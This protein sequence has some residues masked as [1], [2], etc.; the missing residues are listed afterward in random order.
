MMSNLAQLSDRVVADIVRTSLSSV[1]TINTS[2]NHGKN[3]PP[4]VSTAAGGNPPW[5]PQPI[6][7]LLNAREVASILQCHPETIYRKI[8]FEYL[9]AKRL[10]NRWRF[11]PREI[12]DWLKQHTTKQQ[13]PPVEGEA[14]H[15]GD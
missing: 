6:R 11:D 5:N 9:P 3:R 2:G 15:D 1:L 12:A 10:G 14:V 4:T 7:R 13:D 8:R